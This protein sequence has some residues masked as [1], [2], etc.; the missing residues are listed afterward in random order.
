MIARCPGRSEFFI[1]SLWAI[2]ASAKATTLLKSELALIC[3]QVAGKS[4]YLP[5]F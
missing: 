1:A 3:E 4:R 2:A 5:A